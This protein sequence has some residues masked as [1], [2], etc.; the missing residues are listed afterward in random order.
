M[1]GRSV[2]VSGVRYTLMCQYVPKRVTGDIHDVYIYNLS[3]ITR[4]TVP[5]ANGRQQ[6]VPTAPRG[7]K[8][9]KYGPMGCGYVLRPCYN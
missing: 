7:V 1:S 5:S 9:R 8:S 3:N 4:T 6:A 2:G